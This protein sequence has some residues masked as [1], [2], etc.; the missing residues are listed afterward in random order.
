MRHRI[1]LILLLIATCVAANAQKVVL[2]KLGQALN[3]TP[4][5]S[6]PS[7][8]ARVYYRLK[9]Y[10]Y[11]VLQ[12]AKNPS[13]YKVLLQNGTYGY[14]SASLVAKL[15]YDVTA[16]KPGTYARNTEMLTSRSRA[17][18]ASYSLNF[19]GTPY[20]W[21]GNDP[22]GGIDCS[23]FVKFLYGQIGV[24][25]PRTAAE[26]VNVGKRVTRLE[27]LLP[28]DRLYFWSSKRNKIGHT[29]IYLGN[30]FF[31]HSSVNHSGVNTDY[32]SQKW[33]GILVAA[34]R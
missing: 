4:I 22:R 20:K 19:K 26:Q 11:L 21:G 29:G 13:Y 10:E 5:Y 17:A 16:D 28:G 34:R 30:G 3:K 24:N 33:L 27:N 6:R 7:P 15:P 9:P 23:G 14:V 25:L 18:I 32:L 31:V 12:T 1:L 8:R 2:G